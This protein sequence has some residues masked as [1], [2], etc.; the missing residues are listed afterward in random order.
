MGRRV[1]GLNPNLQW[2][3]RD[4][5][6]RTVNSVTI[7]NMMHRLWMKLNRPLTVP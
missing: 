5:S 4:E 3:L 7:H 1:L 2:P 6:L